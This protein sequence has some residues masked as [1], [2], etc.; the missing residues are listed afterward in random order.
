MYRYAYTPFNRV[1]N[2]L[3]Q[4]RYS[5][6]YIESY[7]SGVD[8]PD[9]RK[10]ILSSDNMVSFR[11]RRHRHVRPKMTNSSSSKPAV[12]NKGRPR[13]LKTTSR[14]IYKHKSAM[15]GANK[16]VKAIKAS[17]SNHGPIREPVSNV[18]GGH[19]PDKPSPAQKLFA[20]RVEEVLFPENSTS[21]V[22]N[23][24][25]TA[26]IG[27]CGWIAFNLGLVGDYEACLGEA[28]GTTSINQKILICSQNFSLNI[29]SM[30]NENSY[31]RYYV[32]EPRYD[33]TDQFNLLSG[34]NSG[35]A[36]SGAPV[37]GD[38]KQVN[39]DL[40]STLY[41]N[42]RMMSLF[43]VLKDKTIEME[44]GQS[45]KINL[46]NNHSFVYNH[47]IQVATGSHYTALKGHK[48]LFLVMQ[49]WGQTVDDSVN[50]ALVSTGSVK[51]SIIETQRIN[52]RYC[53]PTFGIHGK[54]A[55]SL[56][57]V[58]IAEAINEET[59]AS[60]AEATV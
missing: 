57:A 5:Q 15:G 58:A 4:N 47:E 20:R 7:L 26:S 43:K 23:T 46:E 54:V 17:T 29:T 35:F 14:F 12:S 11:S 8:T 1:A 31:L 52:Y 9:Y 39:T 40:S 59:G 34:I 3:G 60:S 37:N 32:L 33:L 13:K 16:I 22:T 36:D 55:T 18:F 48:T 28:V 27:Q 21:S 24:Q 56:G 6:S 38:A 41:E 19:R 42:V 45:Q 25:L 53:N 50:P 44:A 2:W 10:D 30:T 51:F 49:C